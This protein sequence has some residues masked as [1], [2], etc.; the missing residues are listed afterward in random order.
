MEVG[1]ILALYFIPTI[2]ANLRRHPNQNAIFILNLL[3]GW[4]LIGWVAALVW[5]AIH[6]RAEDR[7]PSPF[8]RRDRHPDGHVRITSD[9]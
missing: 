5:S 4:T 2:V 3:L 8:A 1:I 6:L 9:N 7:L